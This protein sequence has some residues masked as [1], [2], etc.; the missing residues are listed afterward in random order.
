M[1]AGKQLEHITGGLIKAGFHEVVVN[2]QTI[3][4]IERRKVEV[5]ERPLV[6]ISSTFFW[7]LNSDFDLAPI[8]SL[9]EESKKARAEQFNLGKDEGEE[10]VYPAMKVGQQVQKLV[11][12]MNAL[13]GE[14]LLTELSYRELQ[15]IELMV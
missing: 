7:H 12:V 5:P 2:A 15:H 3:D 8:P 14:N 4:V 6:R 1:Q 11:M 13:V 10:V 9:A